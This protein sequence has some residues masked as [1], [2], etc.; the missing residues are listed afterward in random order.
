MSGLPFTSEEQYKLSVINKAL[1]HE[2]T[3]DYAAKL[4]HLSSRQI[5]RLKKA[6]LLHGPQA[7]VHKLKGKTSNH[8]LPEKQKSFIL[9]LVKE[10]YRDFKPRFA[11][12]K[13][14]ECHNIA[15]NPQTLRR[16][17]TQA[18]LW[19]VRRRKKISYRSWR[20]R[21]EY[22]GELQQ[23]DGSYHHWFEERYA[24]A[25]GNSLEVCLLAAIDDA[26]GQITHAQFAPSE[27]VIPVFTFWK[28]YV[29]HHGKPGGIYL[30]NYST[31]KVPVKYTLEKQHL[32]SQFQRAMKTLSIKLISAHSPQAK[33]RIERLFR[34]LQDRLVKELRL[35]H[36]NAPKE[37][38]IFLKT[39]FIPKFNKHFAVLPAKEGD[40]HRLLTKTEK[41]NLKSIFSIHTIRKV[42]NDFTLLCNHTWYQLTKLQGTTIRP[43]D[44]VIVEQWMDG[45]MHLRYKETYLTY[46]FLPKRPQK[47]QN[48][49]AVTKNKLPWKPPLTH[50][51]KQRYK[52]KS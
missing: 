8:S 7:V 47:V 40:V 21:K 16:W 28:Y 31:Y 12:E 1:T 37:A 14:Q 45:T 10:H 23:F 29:L 15:I 38:N 48:P 42:Q 36:I 19:K 20:P 5:K 35:N 52:T 13:L 27:G 39:V 11:S 32:E 17:M 33:G 25:T 30:D 34:T 22:F 41:A 18:G 9:T 24:D 44:A 46:I 6:V 4:L 2:I 3:N 26:T 43:R 49:V 50:P 51:W